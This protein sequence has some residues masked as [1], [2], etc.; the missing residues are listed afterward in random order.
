MARGFMLTEMASRLPDDRKGRGIQDTVLKGG[1]LPEDVGN[2]ALF[3]A[4]ELSSYITGETI[5]C[6][7][8]MR[9]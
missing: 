8:H 9:N 2:V 4:S 1:G 7:A 5:N 6:S 3:L